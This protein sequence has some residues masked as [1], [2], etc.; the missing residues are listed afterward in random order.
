VIKGFK[1][2]R[3]GKVV[4]LPYGQRSADPTRFFRIRA[5]WGKAYAVCDEPSWK[6][7]LADLRKRNLPAPEPWTPISRKWK[8]RIAAASEAF[9]DHMRRT[10]SPTS[11]DAVQIHERPRHSSPHSLKGPP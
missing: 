8:C 1:I 4:A 5:F 10:L 2:W 9:A 7:C 6:L 11:T 3:G